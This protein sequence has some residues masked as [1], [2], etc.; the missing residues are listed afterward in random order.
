MKTHEEFLEILIT[1]VF[2]ECD[3]KITIETC[4]KDLDCWDSINALTLIALFDSEFEFKLT[5]DKIREASTIQDLYN[6]L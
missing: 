4:F 2:S 5:G 1:E 6:L 3:T